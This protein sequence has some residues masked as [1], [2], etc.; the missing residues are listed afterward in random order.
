M[1]SAPMLTPTPLPAFA[2][3]DKPPSP[4]ECAGMEVDGLGE[5]EDCEVVDMIEDVADAELSVALD[6]EAAAVTLVVGSSA[7]VDDSAK[8]DAA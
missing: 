8:I 3:V 4:L 2:P 7:T 6:K 5:A 1:T